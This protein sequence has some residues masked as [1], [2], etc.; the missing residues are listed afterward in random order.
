MSDYFK[1]PPHSYGENILHYAIIS[2]KKDIVEKIL[3]LGI[4]P[5]VGLATN[6]TPLQSAKMLSFQPETKEIYDLVQCTSLSLVYGDA[7]STHPSHNHIGK[8]TSLD[9]SGMNEEEKREYRRK[10]VID[11]LL[12]TEREYMNDLGIIIKVDKTRDCS[13]LSILVCEPL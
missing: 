1:F 12:E 8:A 2:Q 10:R 6:G 5:R 9:I 11:E 13:L 4:D 7:Q 3:D